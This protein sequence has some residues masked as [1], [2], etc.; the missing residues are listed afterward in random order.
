MNILG[1]TRMVRQQQFAPGE[2]PPLGAKENPVCQAAAR[3]QHRA[4]D[5]LGFG[6]GF[7]GL[8]AAIQAGIAG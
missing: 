3:P 5:K 7:G 6:L 2:K 4:S 8:L 1:N